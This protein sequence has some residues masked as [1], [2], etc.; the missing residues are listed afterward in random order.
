[1]NTSGVGIKPGR[2]TLES[3]AFFWGE[4]MKFVWKKIQH[5]EISE[6]EDLSLT[7]LMDWLLSRKLAEQLV[8]AAAIDGQPVTLALKH[9]ETTLDFFSIHIRQDN[10]AK[11]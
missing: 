2:A 5:E 9:G 4:T 7:R 6:E 10:E 1:M 8:E 11:H 3:K